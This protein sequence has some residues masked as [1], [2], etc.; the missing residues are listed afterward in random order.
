MLSSGISTTAKRNLL[1]INVALLRL[2]VAIERTI[3][4]PT[5][6]LYLSNEYNSSA[7]YFGLCLSG[8]HMAALPSSLL[9]GFLNDWKF[10]VKTL[11]LFGNCFQI[12]GSCLY[13]VR[14]ERFVFPARCIVGFGSCGVGLLMA[15]VNRVTKDSSK[16]TIIS[17]LLICSKMG[18]FFGPALNIFLVDFALKIGPLWIDGYTA[19]G[20]LMAVSWIF[21][22]F[23]MIVTYCDPSEIGI[24]EEEG[25][26]KR[27][28]K[29]FFSPDKE[30]SNEEVIDNGV[31]LKLY[32]K[33]TQGETKMLL[34][35]KGDGVVPSK[36]YCEESEGETNILWSPNKENTI[37]EDNDGGIQS[38]PHGGEAE[39]IP[40]QDQVRPRL[41]LKRYYNEF[42]DVGVVACWAIFFLTSFLQSGWQTLVTPLLVKFFHY[43]TFE[44][45]VVFAVMGIL[46]LVFSVFVGFLGKLRVDDRRLSLTGL[47]LITASVVGA[48]A[49]FP[50]GFFG[51]RNLLAYSGVTVMVFR[52]GYP[53]V[54]IS[55]LSL[56]SKVIRIHSMG[57]AMGVRKVIILLGKI[58]GQVWAGG[59]VDNLYILFGVNLFLVLLMLALFALTYPNLIR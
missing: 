52:M 47:L 53:F 48:L 2:L 26:S 23:F 30:N 40:N 13:L 49:V 34:S 11:V 51:E 45:S 59:L 57:L 28:I 55:S 21:F 17:A 54:N 33:E 42:V 41:I 5:L 15:D 4:M 12:I 56:Y 35:P 44:N 24:V 16:T 25:E 27:E 22:Q 38:Q 6:W 36:L 46:S 9:F 1:Y 7:A 39:T 50:T 3:I 10:R 37:E 19:P 14:D 18:Q 43:G 29:A 20:F 31:R 8:F 32:S 58:L